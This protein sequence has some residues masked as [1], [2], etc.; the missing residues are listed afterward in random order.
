MCTAVALFIVTV[1][2]IF[3]LS[4]KMYFQWVSSELINALINSNSLFFIQLD[5]L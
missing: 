1:V 5:K 2:S 4:Q 3:S